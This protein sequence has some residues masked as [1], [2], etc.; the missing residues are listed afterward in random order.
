MTEISSRFHRPRFAVAALAIRCSAQVPADPQYESSLGAAPYSGG[1]VLHWD[2]PTYTRVTIYGRD[3]KPAY[4]NRLQGAEGWVYDV[5]AVDSEGTVTRAY[6]RHENR[7]SEG[8]IDLLDPAGQTC[9][10]D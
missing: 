3:A 1:Y 2:S 9:G 5:W 8:R 7:R 6:T 4:S 10:H